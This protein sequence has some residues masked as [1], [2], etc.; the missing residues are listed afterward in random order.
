LRVIFFKNHSRRVIQS[1]QL[2][3]PERPRRGVHPYC[4]QPV[5]SDR[6]CKLALPEQ[7]TGGTLYESKVG[8]AKA[9]FSLQK[10]ERLAEAARVFRLKTGRLLQA[11]SDFVEHFPC[12]RKESR[13]LGAATTHSEPYSVG[14]WWLILLALRRLRRLLIPEIP[15]YTTSSLCLFF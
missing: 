10:L 9:A 1:D 3:Q 11:W 5:R 6:R 12:C 15:Q 13:I 14:T 4:L 8:E 2:C 7:L